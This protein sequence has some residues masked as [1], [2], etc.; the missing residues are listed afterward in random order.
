MD[1]FKKWVSHSAK[2]V[3]ESCVCLA[4]A[5]DLL[6]KVGS[7]VGRPRLGSSDHNVGL[8]L[9]GFAIELAYKSVVAANGKRPAPTHKLTELAAKTDRCLR[10][11]MECV[12]R[13]QLRFANRGLIV[14]QL[15]DYVDKEISYTSRRY[16]N[17]TVSGE[18]SSTNFDHLSR[19]DDY[20]SVVAIDVYDAAKALLELSVQTF[21]T[22]GK[23]LDEYQ[24]VSWKTDSLIERFNEPPTVSVLPPSGE[25]AMV[26]D[27]P[28]KTRYSG[29][30]AVEG[31]SR[32]PVNTLHIIPLRTRLVFP[33]CRV[34]AEQVSSDPSPST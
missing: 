1:D 11:R 3:E 13:K 12:I 19:N 9:L 34:H 27:D 33:L 26:Y 16:W 32:K 5:D 8:W 24:T 30:C 15:F 6:R 31:C 4:I 25:R 20:Y 23:G 28:A 22:T 2:Y 21:K 17:V 10:R 18:F 29:V 7:E 14:R